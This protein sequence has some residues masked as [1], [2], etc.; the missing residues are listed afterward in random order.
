MAAAGG[1]RLVLMEGKDL[2]GPVLHLVLHVAVMDGLIR[3][4]LQR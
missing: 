4:A 1:D 3:E 2:G